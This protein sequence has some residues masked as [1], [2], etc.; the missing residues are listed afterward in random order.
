MSDQHNGRTAATP[1]DGFVAA[2]WEPVRE[3]FEANFSQ[4]DR[5][6]ARSPATR[7]QNGGRAAR[8]LTS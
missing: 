8:A 6:L 3:A 4:R 2:G 7:R 5:S 1:I